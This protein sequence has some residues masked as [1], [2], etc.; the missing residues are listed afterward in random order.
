MT[1]KSNK[2]KQLTTYVF[3]DAS[4]IIYGC[5]S[6]GW[7]MDFKKLIKYLK[8]RY[9]AKKVFYLAGLDPENKKQ[10]GFYEKLQEFGYKLRMVPLKTFGDGSK[11]GDVDS[12]MT[13]EI[14]QHYDKYDRAVVLTGDGD[15]F[16][17][18]NHLKEN[19]KKIKIL[20]FPERTA[21]ELKQLVG[22]NFA[23][24]GNLRH[25]LEFKGGK[26]KKKR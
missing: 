20:S 18:L 24:L 2:K 11:K 22:A 10:L 14:M 3:I 1:K 15:Y 16:W 17:V 23:N 12:R 5:K 26:K 25:K 7:K 9:E 6:Q 13:F 4:N 21:K 8:E 19:D